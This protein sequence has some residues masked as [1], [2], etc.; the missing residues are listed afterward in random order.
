MSS[1]V[2][3]C[4]AE[5]QTIK[6]CTTSLIIHLKYLLDLFA[7]IHKDILEKFF[8]ILLFVLQK[9]ILFWEKM[10]LFIPFSTI[11]QWNH[12]KE[13]CLTRE[14]SYIMH[15]SFLVCKLGITIMFNKGMVLIFQLSINNGEC[16]TQNN[17]YYKCL[18]DYLIT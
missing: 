5:L 18:L 15:V 16:R 2:L 14:C 1:T 9:C 13:G 3:Q 4:C 8:L 6:D 10:F 12:D 11:C 17:V 7:K